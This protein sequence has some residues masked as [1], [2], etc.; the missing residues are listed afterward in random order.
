[1]Q[2]DGG[3]VGEGLGGVGQGGAGDAGQVVLGQ[4]GGEG[5]SGGASD[6]G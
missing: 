2:E 6:D 3:G 5:V 4:A 1:V